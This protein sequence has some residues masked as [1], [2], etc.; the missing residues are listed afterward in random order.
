MR[1]ISVVI[2]TLNEK[3]TIE[4][5]LHALGSQSALPDEVV[6][7]DGGSTD[8]TVELVNKLNAL[9]PFDTRVLFC[10]GNI[11]QARNTAIGVA[12]NS[13]IAVTD[14]GS[15]PDRDWIKCLTD[16]ICAR[17]AEAV[18]GS[19]RVVPETRMERAIAIFT[20]IPL[21]ASTKHYL[22]SHRSV[23]FTKDLWR[24]VGG[25]DEL[26]DSGEDTLFDLR[27][28]A[29]S[30]FAYAPMAVVDWRPRGSLKA[31]ARQQLFYGTGDGNA[32][33]QFVYHAVIALLI[34]CEF[35]VFVPSLPIRILS[36][37]GLAVALAHFIRKDA[38][39][40]GFSLFSVPYVALLLLLL[41]A[42]RLVG[43]MLGRTGLRG[44]RFLWVLDS[45]GEQVSTQKS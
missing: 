45:R 20:W 27:V 29:I 25:Y 31:A 14:A 33:I 23:A 17:G 8:G 34:V 42:T 38:G 2:A 12:R 39:L 28:E 43:F 40:F 4:R 21:N 9:L 44:K 24:S 15:I 36:M 5:L 1:N 41:P 13:I 6:I 32:K 19:Y 7:A 37:L 10:P 26:M 11:A 35:G 16:P 3:E 30:S 18:A 22:P